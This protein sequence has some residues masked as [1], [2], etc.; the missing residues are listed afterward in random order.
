MDQADYYKDSLFLE[1]VDKTDKNLGQVE[2]WFAHK[3]GVLHRGFTVVI[4]YLNFFV[5]QHRKHLV[6][7]KVFDLSFSSHP[8]YDKDRLQ[9]N[10]EAIRVALD[11]EWDIKNFSGD[12]KKIGQLYYKAKDD[13]SQYMEHEIDHIYLI[14]LE[15]PPAANLDFAYDFAFIDKQTLKENLCSN[16]IKFAPWTK[17]IIDRMI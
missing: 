1:R 16:K 12:I 13:D 17:E 2:R 10:E 6:F 8:V 9:N 11:R 15:S 14:D 3:E 5:V 7:D 4:R